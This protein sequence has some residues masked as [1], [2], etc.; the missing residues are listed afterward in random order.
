MQHLDK[1]YEAI[2]PMKKV[3]AIRDTDNALTIG[4]SHAIISYLSRKFGCFEQLK[5][6]GNEIV[7]AKV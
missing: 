3:P 6:Q 4:E 5:P 7:L 1:D 2:N